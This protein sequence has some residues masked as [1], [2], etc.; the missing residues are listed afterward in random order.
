MV[1]KRLPEEEEGTVVTIEVLREVS[2]TKFGVK[3]L[4]EVLVRWGGSSPITVQKMGS[5]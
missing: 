2:E 5:T 1:T 4:V 3:D